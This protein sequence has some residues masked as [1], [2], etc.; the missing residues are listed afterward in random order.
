ME[1]ELELESELVLLE[2]ILIGDDKMEGT[3]EFM[4]APTHLKSFLH[5]HCWLLNCPRTYSL[6]DGDSPH[7]TRCC[8]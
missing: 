2:G 6:L 3:V 8:G 5:L 1:L 4:Y 7:A